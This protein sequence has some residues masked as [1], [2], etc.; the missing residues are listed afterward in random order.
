MNVQQL[1]GR[2]LD[3]Y[4][5]FISNFFFLQL[6]KN[7]AE[8]VACRGFSMS[9]SS[10]LL[11]ELQKCNAVSQHQ[12]FISGF[13]N[14]WDIFQIAGSHPL[15]KYFEMI[16]YY[17]R[18]DFYGLIFQNGQISNLLKSSENKLLILILKMGDEFQGNSG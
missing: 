13:S 1:N 5:I 3:L 9:A 11:P 10:V 14:G 16:Q 15:V 12:V 18:L 17:Y 6:L 4:Q 2:L 8:Y 7:I